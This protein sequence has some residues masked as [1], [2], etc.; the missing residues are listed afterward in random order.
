MK[1][2]GLHEDN[3]IPWLQVVNP[4]KLGIPKWDHKLCCQCWQHNLQ[5]ASVS[6][7]APR[8]ISLLCCH[9]ETLDQL[10]VLIYTPPHKPCACEVQRRWQLPA[11]FSWLSSNHHTAVSCFAHKHDSKI[12]IA[13][14]AIAAVRLLLLHTA[15]RWYVYASNNYLAV[16]QQVCKYHREECNDVF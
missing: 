4:D 1:A 14:T 7:E 11:G 3:A 8:A 12:R 5:S 10:R 15:A 2:L 6:F 13:Q 16:P 9:Q